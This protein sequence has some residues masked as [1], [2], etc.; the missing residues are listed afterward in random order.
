MLDRTAYPVRSYD[1]Y[2]IRQIVDEALTVIITIVACMHAYL[3]I[4]IPT[5]PTAPL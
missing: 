5:L 4:D 2:F 3:Y 1:D